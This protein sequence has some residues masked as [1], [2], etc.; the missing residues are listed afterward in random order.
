MAA[1]YN[2]RIAVPERAR[3]GEVIEI[4]TLIAH[5]MESGFRRDALGQQIPRNIL[6]S[7]VCRYDG[8]EVFRAEFF[9]AIAANPFL[10]FHVRATKSADLEF[11][12]QDQDGSLTQATARLTVE[13]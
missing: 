13:P 1:E 7:F 6:R 10:A 11:E 5:P 12:W 2:T 8:R 4:K 9:P 3:A